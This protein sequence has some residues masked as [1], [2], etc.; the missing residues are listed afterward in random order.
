MRYQS[1]FNTALFI[2]QQ[3]KG[4]MPLAHFLKQYFVQHKKHG[5]RDRKLI[6][7]LCYAY[8]RLGKSLLNE[9]PENRLKIAMYLLLDQPGEW[10]IIFEKEWLANWPLNLLERWYLLKQKHPELNECTIFPF[11]NAFSCDLDVHAFIHSFF[12]QPNTFIRVRPG[13]YQTVL[14]QLYQAGISFQAIN[15]YTISFPAATNIARYLT[16]EEAYVVQ[17]YSSQQVLTLM[18]LIKDNDSTLAVWDCCAASGG[19][20]ILANDVWGNIQ[21]TV[22]DVRESVLHNLVQRFKQAKIKNYTAVIADVSKPLPTQL[23]NKQFEVIIAD[24]PCTG[25]GTWSRT[26]EQLY[27]FSSKQIENYSL[28]Q[29]DIV[30]KVIPQLKPGGYFLYITCSVFKQENEQIVNQIIQQ[31]GLHLIKQLLLTG[32]HI[33][34]DTMFA[35]LLQKPMNSK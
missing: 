28:L 12:I 6:A 2:V 15:D 22:S 10:Q 29:K 8:F 3:Y 1:Y 27:F 25:S 32:Y 23:A 33:Q 31:E 18:Q 34:A 4:E 17:D 24:V 20:S 13:W 19:K 9:R 5:S 30:H 7:H 21:L 16:N 26:P 11:Q 14:Q 35:A